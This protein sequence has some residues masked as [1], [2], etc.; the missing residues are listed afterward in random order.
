MIRIH[1]E[2]IKPPGP[3]W[4][5][6]VEPDL[7]F[8]LRINSEGWR[9]GSVEIVRLPHHDFLQYD[10]FIE[11]GDP[12]E[13]DG[14]VVEHAL[15]DKGIVGRIDPSLAPDIGAAVQSCSL[16]ARADKLAIQQALSVF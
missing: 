16:I 12:L 14:Y 15:A 5:V 10:S 3:K 8:F 13:L 1:D 11:C 4:V 7:G 6:C 9:D 2:H